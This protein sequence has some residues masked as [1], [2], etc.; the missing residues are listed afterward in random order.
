MFA[1]VLSACGGTTV[2]SKPQRTAEVVPVAEPRSK[3]GNPASY[4]VLGKRYYVLQ[5][6]AGYKDKGIASWYGPNFHGKRASSGETYNMNAMT[7]AH[8]TL[9]LPTYVRVS[10]L[11]NGRSII[12]KVNDRGPFHDNRIID[13]S[14]AAA[15]Q[16]DV[17]RTGTA[18]V[19]VEVV[20]S[21]APSNTV[22][23]SN[24]S[25][26]KATIDLVSQQS[27]NFIYIQLGAFSAKQN[28]EQLLGRLLLSNVG[29]AAI[30]ESENN[31]NLIYRVRI[32]PLSSVAITDQV[33]A[34]LDTLGF[35]EYQIVIE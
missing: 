9:P 13:L 4:V 18:L 19:Q 27:Q 14:K 20:S 33:A 22:D 24:V 5:S 26:S 29:G 17:V 35:S 25:K 34:K 8:K 1:V 3:Y 31:G 10:N 2:V 28:A 6:A 16:L 7:A 30:T 32:G 23:L 11:E 12:V 21:S 15:T